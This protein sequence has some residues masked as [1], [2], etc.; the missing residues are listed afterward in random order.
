MKH[1]SGYN[2]RYRYTEIIGEEGITLFLIEFKEN[3]KTKCGAWVTERKWEMG[4]KRFVLDGI[5]KR[6]CH[7]T[8]EMAFDS[9]KMR[10]KSQLRY[11]QNALDIATFMINET[12]NLTKAPEQSISLGCPDF[13]EGYYFD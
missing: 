3:K 5:G 8:K 10:K 11:A 9:Y 4:K 7:E 12:A 13:W 2:M 1:W 6:Y